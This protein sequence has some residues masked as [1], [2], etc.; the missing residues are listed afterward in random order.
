M[1]SRS[2]SLT[3]LDLTSFDTSQVAD[4]REMFSGC[5]SLT[6]ILSFTFR[7]CLASEA[8]FHECFSLQGAVNFNEKCTN[9]R[10]ANPERGY[11]TKKV[12]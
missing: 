4:M 2:K 3:S 1:F 9:A 10:M 11:F 5:S 12:L 8:M 6:T 7:N